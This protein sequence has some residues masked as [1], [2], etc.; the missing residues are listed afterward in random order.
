MDESASGLPAASEDT[1]KSD[2]QRDG[3]E[4]AAREAMPS[5]APAVSVV[6]IRADVRSM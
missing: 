3:Q 5:V 4:S 6:P 1:V 2:E